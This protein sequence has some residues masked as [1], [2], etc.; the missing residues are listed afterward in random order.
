MK[1]SFLF[2]LNQIRDTTIP[3]SMLAGFPYVPVV[4]IF[5]MPQ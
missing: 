4:G 5:T 3:I 1:S 2:G